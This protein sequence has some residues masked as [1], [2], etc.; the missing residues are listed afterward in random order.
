MKNALRSAVLAAAI[1]SL[2]ACS[3]SS[4]AAP[5]PPANIAGSYTATVTASSTCSA[6]LPSETRV[7]SYAADVSQ[8][9]ANAQVKINPHGGTS[10]TVASTVSGQTVSFPAVSFSATTPGGVVVSIVA[11]TGTAN[12]AANKEIAGTLSGTFQTASGA[13]CNASDH[14]LQMKPCVVT[15]SG[16]VCVCG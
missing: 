5:T 13:S 10:V 15:C 8:T 6:N 1:G 2:M 4:P 7:L 3:D 16:N 9:G 11:T 12:I 14:Q